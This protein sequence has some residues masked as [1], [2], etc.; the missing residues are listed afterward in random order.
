MFAYCLLSNHVHLVVVPPRPESLGLLMQRLS[1]RYPRY[2]N[3]R[4]RRSGTA[5]EE[6]FHS[7]PIGS[8]AY[9]LAC[10]RYVDLNPVRAGIVAFAG[11]YRWQAEQ[12]ERAVRAQG[13][14]R[15]LRLCLHLCNRV[16]SMAL[17]RPIRL[18]ERPRST[19]NRFYL[20]IERA[21][22]CTVD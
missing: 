4:Y 6:R 7:S 3:E 16:S 17:F 21:G 11:D 9:L 2:F 1:G 10:C 20:L 15:L 14:S 8:D 22:T 19:T 5:W 13:R 12:F 18:S